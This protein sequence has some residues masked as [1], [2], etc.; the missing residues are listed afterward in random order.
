V[1]WAIA[2]LRCLISVAFTNV[3][4]IS[5]AGVCG[6]GKNLDMLVMSGFICLMS[7]SVFWKAVGISPGKPQ[8]MSVAI[9][10]WG[11]VVLNLFMVVLK[12]CVV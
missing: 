3:S 11:K 4:R 9:V 5:A 12:F 7:L 10:I 6:L 2:V 1:S 8:M